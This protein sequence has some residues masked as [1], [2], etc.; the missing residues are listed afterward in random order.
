[1][2]RSVA[3]ELVKGQQ[4]ISQVA[5][6]VVGEAAQTLD[7]RG[8]KAAEEAG[9]LNWRYARSAGSRGTSASACVKRKAK[10]ALPRMT[11][12][13]QDSGDGSRPP[14]TARKGDRRVTEAAMA[15]NDERE[16]RGV[17]GRRRSRSAT[18]QN[19]EPNGDEGIVETPAC[20]SSASTAR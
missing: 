7:K 15:E 8:P 9:I 16:E 11:K 10:A 19:G 17:R 13:E 1:M 12:R 6:T 2:A 5:R 20:P 14:R 3:G 4:P 18:A